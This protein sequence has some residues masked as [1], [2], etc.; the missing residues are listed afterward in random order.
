MAATMDSFWRQYLV[1]DHIVWAP[2]LTAGIYAVTRALGAR[3]V[4]VPNCCCA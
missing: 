1:T 3:R 2:R 4:I